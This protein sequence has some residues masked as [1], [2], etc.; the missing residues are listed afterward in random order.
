MDKQ[1]MTLSMRPVFLLASRFPFNFRYINI[2]EI[3]NILLN[4]FSSLKQF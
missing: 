3:E 1:G 4:S 2:L